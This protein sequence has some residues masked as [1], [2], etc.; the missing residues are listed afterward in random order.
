MLNPILDLK[1][2]L[3]NNAIQGF[4]EATSRISTQFPNATITVGHVA[5]TENPADGMTKLFKDPI[6]I[7]NSRIYR[8]GPPKFGNLES[9]RE[10]KVAICSNGEFQFLGLPAKFLSE[11]SKNGNDSCHL[12][13]EG[14]QF[15]GLV[16]TRNRAKRENV[17][18]KEDEERTKNRKLKVMQED[19]CTPKTKQK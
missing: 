8:E 13:G 1:N 14:I 2:M 6:A 18:D 4:K 5:G 10:D 15:C 3:I 16:M 7:I 12:C 19:L 17:E 11:D 9:L